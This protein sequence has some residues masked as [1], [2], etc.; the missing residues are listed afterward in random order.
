M[1]LDRVR[2]SPNPNPLTTSSSLP[3]LLPSTDL[4]QLE[5]SH[6]NEVVLNTE[7]LAL[8]PLVVCLLLLSAQTGPWCCRTP[9]QDTQHIC[10]LLPFL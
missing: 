10:P 4:I 7:A 8:G 5:T 9:Q 2:V 1:I 6:L 3:G